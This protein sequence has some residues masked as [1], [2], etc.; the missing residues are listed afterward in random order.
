MRSLHAVALVGLCAAK[1]TAQWVTPA[2]TAPGVQQRVFFSPAA[3]TNVSYHVYTPPSYASQPNR[4]FPVL[5]WLHGSGS[6]LPGIA[7]MSS[8]LG[9]AMAQQKIPPM[10][11]V[12]PNG[13]PYGMWCNAASGATPIEDVVL[14]ELIPRVDADF[15][16]IPAQQARLV[17]GFSMGGYGAARFALKRPDLFVGVSVF[18]GGPLQTDLLDAPPNPTLPKDLRLRIYRDV[19]NSDPSVFYAQSPW[20]LAGLYASAPPARPLLIRQIIGDLDF[21]LPANLD[22]HDRL[23]SLAIPHAFSL[24]PGVGHDMPALLDALGDQH[25]A[26]YVAAFSN[27]T[28]C[29]ANCDGSAT[30]PILT[31]A[32]FSCFLARYR[33]ADQYANCDG[34]TAQPMLSPADFSCFLARYRAGCP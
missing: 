33:S 18:A 26:F 20:N 10:I 15:R 7:P 34:S 11:V 1:A 13:M 8:R 4:R 2:V 9:A 23:D 19:Y 24:V 21:T 31:P 29:F 30:A 22:F 3:G 32:D 25:W 27:T 5:Y 16:T 17:E 12:F 28:A 14:N 6:V